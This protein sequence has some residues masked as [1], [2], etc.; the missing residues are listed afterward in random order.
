M[1][2]E[3]RDLFVLLLVHLRLLFTV[4]LPGPLHLSCGKTSLLRICQHKCRQPR[5]WNPSQNMSLGLVGT[6]TATPATTTPIAVTHFTFR[7]LTAV[8]IAVLFCIAAFYSFVLAY[9]LCLLLFCS[10][11]FVYVRG[12]PWTVRES[13]NAGALSPDMELLSVDRSFRPKIEQVHEQCEKSQRVQGKEREGATLSAASGT[14]SV[15]T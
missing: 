8:A 4:L 3:D 10:F 5:R 14:E 1:T 6:A 13:L 7:Q 2:T 11:L 15:T 9:R 12:I